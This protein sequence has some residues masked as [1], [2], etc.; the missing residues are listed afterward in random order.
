M[1]F[2]C[3]FLLYHLV[4]HLV[5]NVSLTLLSV[6]HFFFYYVASPTFIIK[7]LFF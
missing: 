7:V 3:V 1:G 2:V 6:Y 4:F 5:E